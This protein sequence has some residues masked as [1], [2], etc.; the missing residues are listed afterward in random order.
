MPNTKEF[1]YLG[2]SESGNYLFRQGEYE[3]VL[4][5]SQ[6]QQMRVLC[7]QVLPQEYEPIPDYGDLMTI[8]EY[9]ECVNGGGFV[10]YDGFGYASD[11]KVMFTEKRIRPSDGEPFGY[12][13]VVWFNK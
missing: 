4:D 13:H 11:G 6:M 12:T 2:I 9:M 5:K 10:D 8:E 1:V 3:F 7:E